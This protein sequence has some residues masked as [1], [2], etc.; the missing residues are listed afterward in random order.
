MLYF[1]NRLT[2]F[3]R[4]YYIALLSWTRSQGNWSKATV[5]TLYFFGYFQNSDSNLAMCLLTDIFF[6]SWPE[7]R[8]TEDQRQ[9]RNLDSLRSKRLTTDP[10]FQSVKSDNHIIQPKSK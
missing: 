3:D 7:L 5:V 9:I 10:K 1:L 4:K 8:Q 2:A 6:V